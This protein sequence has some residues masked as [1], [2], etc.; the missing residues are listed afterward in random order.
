MFLAQFST[1]IGREPNRLEYIIIA[2]AFFGLFFSTSFFHFF[3]F[4]LVIRSVVISSKYARFA[5][6][7]RLF[8]HYQ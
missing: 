6:N 4:H 7:E 1:S 5:S 8:Y 2:I 3:S